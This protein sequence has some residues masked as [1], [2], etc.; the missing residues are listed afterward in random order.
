MPDG[1]VLKNAE[2]ARDWVAG[3]GMQWIW[4]LGGGSEIVLALVHRQEGGGATDCCR[5]H[6]TGVR[7]G[8]FFDARAMRICG[9]R[10][11]WTVKAWCSD[12]GEVLSAIVSSAQTQP[13]L[14]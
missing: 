11:G 12:G 8:L 10:E 3:R 7:N 4:R 6:C 14:R 9:M 2:V 5:R 13:L 1:A